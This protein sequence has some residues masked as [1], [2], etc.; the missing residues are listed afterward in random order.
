MTIAQANAI[1]D[2]SGDRG[3]DPHRGNT[4]IRTVDDLMASLEGHPTT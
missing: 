3:D 1:L 2:E 4:P